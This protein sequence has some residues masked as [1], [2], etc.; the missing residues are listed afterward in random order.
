MAFIKGKNLRLTFDG[1][2]LL[3]AT[4]CQLS[5]AS[6]T[7]EIA[8]KDTVGDE[9]L[10]SGYNYSLSTSAL[11]ATLP[12]GNTTHVVADVLVEA[13]VAG[14]PVA[15]EFTS[16]EAGTKVY[17]GTCFVTQSDM[18]ASNGSSANTS[19]SLTGTGDIVIEDVD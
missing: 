1:K 2:K 16:G 3:H 19:F 7:E 14:T 12:V 9:L 17:S 11:M 10:I 4:E 13:Q 8:T 5:I 18:T 6:K 15:W